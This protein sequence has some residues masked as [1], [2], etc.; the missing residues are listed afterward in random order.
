VFGRVAVDLLPGPS[1]I[2][3]IADAT[4]N[5]AFV[6]A[7]MLAQAEHGHGSAVGLVTTSK[8]LITSV[9]KELK[10]QAAQLARQQ[11]LEEVLDA[12]TFLVL[13]KSLDQAV[14]IANDFSPE[15]LS[16]VAK[17][18]EKLARGIRTSGAIFLGS[19]SPV[20]GGDFV[21]GPSHEL[22]TGGAGKS[23]GGLTVDQFQ[24]RTS[25]V[26]FDKASLKKSLPAIQTF[27]DVE[28]LD[29]HGNSATI[30]LSGK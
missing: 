25:I 7:D 9:Q 20:V 22:P 16:I 1:E 5:A 15:H 10:K 28:G 3:V 19:L 4:A 23:F 13:V 24:R 26:R 17:E 6:A 8:R 18:E 11:H 2:L 30:R 29:A 12:N 27:S 14:E 21:A